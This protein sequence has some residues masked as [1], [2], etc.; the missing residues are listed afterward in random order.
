MRY[1]EFSVDRAYA[2]S[3]NQTLAD[4]RRLQVSAVVTA[5]L[6]AAAGAWLIRLAHPW[7]IV[8]GILVALGA[9]GS[10]WVAFWVPRKVG[11]IEDL[12][13]RSPLVP[14]VVSEIHP[15]A[16]TLLSLID[17]AKP[18][19]A[20]PSY[21]LVTR[22]IPIR[23]GQKQNIGDK[24]PSVALLNDRSTRSTGS[25]WEMVSPMPIAWGTRDSSVRARAAEAV[26]RVEWDFLSSRI[27]QSEQ[28]RTSA[29]QR[30]AVP[31][32]ELPEGLH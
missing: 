23:A 22:N 4:V 7:S 27:D 10:L 24:V 9:L 19:T 15:R 6:F 14:A 2:R 5:L 30:L 21:V 20:G 13:A 17:I 8:L 11:S 32:E 16:L 1:F 26:S 12:Y 31:A 3:V 18:G 29:E 28:I 25:T